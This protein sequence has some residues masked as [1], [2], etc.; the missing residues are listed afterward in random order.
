[1]FCDKCGKEINGS[2]KFCTR[3]GNEIITDERKIV[4][5]ESKPKRKQRGVYVVVATVVLLLFFLLMVLFSG[6]EEKVNPS[7]VAD[8][9]NKV[10]ENIE[11][12]ETIEDEIIEAAESIEPEVQKKYL[13]IEETHWVESSSESE[14]PMMYISTF[15]YDVY[16]NRILEKN[17]IPDYDLEVFRAF[18]YDERGKKIS[19]KTYY[20]DGTV[21]SVIKY[22]YDNEGNLTRESDFVGE[23][24]LE[25]YI[26]YA[27]DDKGNVTKKQTY[28]EN[29]EL[30]SEI[31]YMYDTDNQIVREEHIYVGELNRI[32]EYS[33]TES[34]EKAIS[35]G[36][37]GAAFSTKERIFDDDGNLYEEIHYADD[38]NNP[39][40]WDQHFYE[41]NNEI[42]M[43]DK[44]SGKTYNYLYDENGNLVSEEVE[45]A[46]ETYNLISSYKYDLFEI[47]KY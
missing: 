29:G 36:K 37:D 5:D 4:S 47:I 6:V 16:G 32:V 35:Y 12:V 30:Y 7:K 24:V 42:K 1:M 10:D 17:Y 34:T 26:D 9:T 19:D 27:Y 33:Y 15:E 8:N 11:S 41:G 3:C 21:E 40:V 20:A 45:N 22:E 38:R 2:E 43:I 44:K 39:I 28:F 23:D 14:F 25:L 13:C 18:E 31:N 46:D